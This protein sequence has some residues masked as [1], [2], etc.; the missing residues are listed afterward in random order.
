M[1]NEKHKF[2]LG[3]LVKIE[4]CPARP[5]CLCFFCGSD[6][7]RIGIVLRRAQQPRLAKRIRWQVRFDAGEWDLYESEAEVFARAK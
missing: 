3:D 1:K 6:S 5:G 7:S 2:Q 4:K